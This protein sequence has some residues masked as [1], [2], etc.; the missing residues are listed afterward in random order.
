M[1]KGLWCV[2]IKFNT[3]IEAFNY[4]R[5]MKKYLNDEVNYRTYDDVNDIHYISISI[6]KKIILKK[7]YE[8]LSGIYTQSNKNTFK[9]YLFFTYEDYQYIK[10]KYKYTKIFLSKEKKE[11]IKEF[12]KKIK[13]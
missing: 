5:S 12:F 13:S 2:F 7:E 10:N 8:F 9:T 6:N 11:F 1:K 4:Y 3:R